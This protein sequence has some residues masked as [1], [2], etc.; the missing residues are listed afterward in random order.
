[1][2]SVSTPFVAALAVMLLGSPLVAGCGLQS[3]IN[4]E[5]SS[6]APDSECENHPARKI[7]EDDYTKA[8]EIDPID[9]DAYYNR[10]GANM[11]LGDRKNACIDFKKAASLGDKDAAEWVRDQCQ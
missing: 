4:E 6:L 2:P 9:A 10:G 5:S 1:M 8:M 3:D 7:L 11:V